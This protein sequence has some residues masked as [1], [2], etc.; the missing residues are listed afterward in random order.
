MIIIEPGV[1]IANYFG[2][3]PTIKSLS[4]VRLKEIKSH[5]DSYFHEKGKYL[6]CNISEESIQDFVNDNWYFKKDG[7]DI[8]FLCNT[9]SELNDFY[10]SLFGIFNSS[11]DEE[12]QK[13]KSD[14]LKAI[15]EAVVK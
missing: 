11:F 13:I 7:S 2:E 5:V 1:L 15:E 4:C 8:L 6:T 12:A 14:L 10:Q 3:N 9:E